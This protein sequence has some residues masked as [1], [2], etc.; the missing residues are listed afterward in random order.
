MKGG[1]TWCAAAA[2]FAL[3]AA[4][5]PAFA[6]R[7]ACFVIQS[8][9]TASSLAWHLTGD[10]EHRYAAWFRILDPATS[11]F[12]PKARYASI[13]PGWHVCIAEERVLDALLAVPT[14]TSG[15]APRVVPATP[16]G[17]SGAA[18]RVVPALPAGAPHEQPV[19][20]DSAGQLARG[21]LV[22][23]VCGILVLLTTLLAWRIATDY[24]TERRTL[25]SIMTLFGERF[26]C[27]FER[28]LR[29]PGCHEQALESRLRFLPQQRRLDILLAPYKG[30]T[31]PN[32]SDHRKNVE[33]D[34]GRVLQLLKDERFVS[35]RLSVQGRWVIVACRLRA[36]LQLGGRQ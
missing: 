35:E 12:I 24:S 34:V 4:A 1:I 15:A 3:A 5:Q 30:R 7:F 29:R 10:A 2:A 33:Y 19:A 9:D 28:P 11:R 25:V 6:S 17:P 36:D 18:P 8:G 20:T 23:V 22:G 16:A 14:L 13:L 27:E 26:I 31:Y 21:G 32:L